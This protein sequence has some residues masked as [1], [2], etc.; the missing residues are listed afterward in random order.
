MKMDR[1]AARAQHHSHQVAG[2]GW[3]HPHIE[4]DPW[5]DIDAEGGITRTLSM[6]LTRAAYYFFRPVRAT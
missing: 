5:M 1:T 4:V 6:Y 3:P 2:Q